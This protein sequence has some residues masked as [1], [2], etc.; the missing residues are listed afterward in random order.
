MSY[1]PVAIMTKIERM[2][3]LGAA[4]VAA[5][6]AVWMVPEFRCYAG[7][8]SDSSC[9][10]SANTL[11]EFPEPH[12]RLAL[13]F[14][15]TEDPRIARI[16]TRYNEIEARHRSSYSADAPLAWRGADSAK[17]TVYRGPTQIEKVRLRVFRAQERT[18][19]LFY[20]S[21]NSLFFVHQVSRTTADERR[22]QRFYFDDGRMIRWLGPGNTPVSDRA[23]EFARNADDLARLGTHLLA[24]GGG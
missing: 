9:G 6:A 23:P 2:L 11:P 20:Y 24:I 4:L 7:L 16:R 21:R 1:I 12:S 19:L 8:D 17:L 5:A 3:S 22:E 13:H 14:V 18:S 10:A 15:P